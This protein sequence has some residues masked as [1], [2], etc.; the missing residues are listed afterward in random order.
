MI[1]VNKLKGK[2]LTNIGRLLGV[3]RKWFGLEPDFMF[4]KR[5]N[6]TTGVKC[7]SGSDFMRKGGE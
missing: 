5:V 4:R 6:N 1:N 3:E 7:Y 2:H